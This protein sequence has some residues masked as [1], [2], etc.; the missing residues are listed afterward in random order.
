[1]C[2]DE[3]SVEA[4]APLDST[5]ERRTNVSGKELRGHQ[6]TLLGILAPLKAQTRTGAMQRELGGLCLDNKRGD[7]EGDIWWLARVAQLCEGR[8]GRPD[9]ASRPPAP[10]AT[11]EV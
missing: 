11:H 9:D 10:T 8:C 3:Y 7:T 4:T 2:G 1:M 6:S 5:S